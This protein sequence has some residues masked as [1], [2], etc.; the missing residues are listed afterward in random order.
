METPLHIAS[1]RGHDSVVDMLL[2]N[3]AV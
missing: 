3:G 1:E 2:K